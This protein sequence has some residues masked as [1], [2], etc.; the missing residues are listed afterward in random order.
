MAM[1][2]VVLNIALMLAVAFSMVHALGA[3]PNKSTRVAFV[4]GMLGEVLI[5][6]Y[7]GGQFSI[8]MVLL[9]IT[10]HLGG[11]MAIKAIGT[12]SEE[13]KLGSVYIAAIFLAPLA[14]L[15]AGYIMGVHFNEVIVILAVF[16]TYTSIIGSIYAYAIKGKREQLERRM[17]SRL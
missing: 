11:L 10:S 1:L 2:D 13:T 5:I 4:T 9:V 15:A 16:A 17:A 3:L 7:L 14:S 8:F 12:D 6:S